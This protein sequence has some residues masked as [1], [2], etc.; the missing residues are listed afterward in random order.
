MYM[1]RVII[2]LHEINTSSVDFKY[3]YQV[4]ADTNIY[5]LVLVSTVILQMLKLKYLLDKII[6]NKIWLSLI[7][8]NTIRIQAKFDRKDK[9]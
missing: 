1:L 6:I 8:H 2:S 7:I 9:T 3:M 5:R 4:L